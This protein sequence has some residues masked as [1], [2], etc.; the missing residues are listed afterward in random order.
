MHDPGEIGTRS[1]IIETADEC[2]YFAKREGR[3]RSF[4]RELGVEGVVAC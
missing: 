3:N 2:L 4:S 1:Q